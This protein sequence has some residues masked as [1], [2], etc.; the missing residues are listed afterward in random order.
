MK[1]VLPFV[2][3]SMRI[4]SVWENI[5]SSASIFEG[6]PEVN[7]DKH[8]NAASGEYFLAE[9][10]IIAPG[11]EPLSVTRVYLSEGAAFGGEKWTLLPHVLLKERPG[12]TEFLT[13]YDPD[14]SP[15]VF[16]EKRG[17]PDFVFNASVYGGGLSNAAKGEVSNQTNFKYYKAFRFSNKHVEVTTASGIKRNYKR[18]HHR[19]LTYFL[20]EEVLP[21]THRIRYTYSTTGRITSI[22]SWNASY[23]KKFAE[24]TF[25]YDDCQQYLLMTTH[26]GD[27]VKYWYEKGKSEKGVFHRCLNRFTTSTGKEETLAFERHNEWEKFRVSKRSF[28]DGSKHFVRYY[29]QDEQY[30]IFNQGSFTV[31]KGDPRVGKVESVGI[32]VDGSGTSEMLYQMMYHIPNNYRGEYI[33]NPVSEVVYA[34]NTKE[35]YEFTTRYALK[36]HSIHDPAGRER[37][38]TSYKFTEKG[39]LLD[40]LHKKDGKTYLLEHYV[41][42]GNSLIATETSGFLTGEGW[43]TL[44]RNYRWSDDDMH[45]LI[46]VKTNEEKAI[47]ISYL[48]KTN[49]PVEIIEEGRRCFHYRRTRFTY[50]E[51]GLLIE[52]ILDDPISTDD[53]S[54]RQCTMQKK[55]TYT[56]RQKEPA[57]GYPDVEEEYGFDFETSEYKRICKKQYHYNEKC[58]VTSVDCYDA[59]GSLRYTLFYRYD[60]EGRCIY[61]TDPLGR[62]TKRVYNASGLLEYE[63][64]GNSQIA[65]NKLYD[66]AHRLIQ[67][68]AISVNDGVVKTKTYHYNLMGHLLEEEDEFG[69]RTKYTRNC[70]GFLEEKESKDVFDEKKVT[71]YKNDGLGRILE[72]EDP[73]KRVNKYEYTA[74]GKKKTEDRFNAP[75]KNHVYSPEGL[76]LQTIDNTTTTEYEYDEFGRCVSE[77]TI[78]HTETASRTNDRRYSGFFL[79]RDSS[80][81]EKCTWYEYDHAGRLVL[82]D[83]LLVKKT[84]TYDSLGY[85]SCE[86][87]KDSWGKL[88]KK[89]YTR[90][91]AGRVTEEVHVNGHENVIYNAFYLYDIADNVIAEGV[92]FAGKKMLTVRRYDGFNRVIQET[93]RAGE[94]TH[95]EYIDGVEYKQLACRVKK[96]YLPSG[97]MVQETFH[98]EGFILEKRIVS[99]ALQRETVEEY[100]YNLA[101]DLVLQKFIG[102][103]EICLRNTYDKHGRLISFEEVF[104]HTSRTTQYEYD[105]AFHVQKINKPNGSSLERKH[106][107]FG[108]IEMLSES[109]KGTK[110]TFAY[111]RRGLLT[112]IESSDQ[113]STIER[114]YS[115]R[116]YLEYEKFANGVEVEQCRDCNRRKKLLRISGGCLLE[117]TYE[118]FLPKDIIGKFSYSS[119]KQILHSYV[120]YNEIGKCHEEQRVDGTKVRTTY[121]DSGR[122]TSIASDTECEKIGG[123]DADGNVISHTLFNRSINY[124]YDEKSQVTSEN[125][126]TYSFTP[127]GYCNSKNGIPVVREDGKIVQVGSTRYE[128]DACGRR[129]KKST[130]E[131]ETVYAYDGFDRLVEVTTPEITITYTYDGLNRLVSEKKGS[132]TS[133]FI[134]EDMCELGVFDENNTMRALRVPGFK[135]G[136]MAGN[137]VGI[138]LDR[139]FYIT[140]TDIQ[141][142]IRALYTQEGELV[143]TYDHTLFG[144]GHP[145]TTRSPW[146]YQSKRY[147]KETGLFFFGNRFYD[148]EIASWISPD[149]LGY[150]NGMNLYQ[151]LSNNPFKYTDEFGDEPFEAE[152]FT[153]VTSANTYEW[154]RP[155][156]SI[157]CRYESSFVESGQSRITSLTLLEPGNKKYRETN[158]LNT[159][160][161]M[162]VINGIRTS[163]EEAI[164][165]GKY[166]SNMAGGRNVHILY[167]QS[168]GTYTD[169]NETPSLLEGGRAKPAKMLQSFIELAHSIHGKD[170]SMLILSHSQGASHTFNALSR[171]SDEVRKCVHAI[172][173]AG[174]RHIP[175]TFAQSSIN[176]RSSY[177]R[178]IVPMMQYVWYFFHPNPVQYAK[179]FIGKKNIRVLKSL[180]QSPALD[181][182]FLSPTFNNSMKLS[183][184]NYLKGKGVSEL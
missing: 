174:V 106:T 136:E 113:K 161:Q 129:T 171:L 135:D 12:S 115:S 5:E 168:H 36:K 138:V 37:S 84:Y 147:C 177:F 75:L 71:K 126:I 41:Y 92:R 133:Y 39:F 120:S 42:N 76:L 183:I 48:D 123:Y 105:H 100:V 89:Y 78:P 54:V 99:P 68:A 70:L 16:Q 26:S 27:W 181:H 40:K 29:K 45:N 6:V 50:D 88:L 173:I 167:N 20:V 103:D 117:Y 65:F 150:K 61:E 164:D 130:P 140:S 85:V 56:R 64:K 124:T 9:T 110:Y 114:G 119:K 80:Y 158:L 22:A 77:T 7:I 96:T 55:T 143:E 49:L 139:T 81:D 170:L 157:Y 93:N 137:T 3:L 53:P 149:Q 118:G 62:E 1:F 57:L 94:T 127:Q 165:M 34:N 72:E 52:K 122:V 83:N 121:D 111:D 13:T 112:K 51:D 132:E 128:Y 178:D 148:P 67:E 104:P 8:V 2:L 63:K 98:P 32:D 69:N 175:T 182:S 4:F 38:S 21:N 87:E 86:T 152:S 154:A 10:D 30:S 24:I 43:S 19:D 35:R 144:E 31:K 180:P 179:T 125:N 79:L 23:T 101:G 82:E 25:E 109:E 60:R 141:G 102:E 116:G 17:T 163:Y 169:L 47:R 162:L 91:L 28:Q 66:N 44:R 58:Q 90:D 160:Y 151:F 108:E 14:G 15:L 153:D 107:P 176:Y 18:Q 142:N 156:S 95:Y 184:D 131:G 97:L 11:V 74:H 134:Y 159:P 166:V 155:D 46:E 73:L 146:T 33:N 145:E 172:N 59:E